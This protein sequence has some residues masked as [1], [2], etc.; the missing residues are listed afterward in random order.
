M[1][2]LNSLESADNLL[3][4]FLVG[5]TFFLKGNGTFTF[6]VTGLGGKN[7]GSDIVETSSSSPSSGDEVACRFEVLLCGGDLEA[8]L[9]RRLGAISSS[10]PTKCRLE[11]MVVVEQN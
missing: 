6:A 5:S 9:L 11:S 8:I 7:A 2:C 3:V 10:Q 1:P 4:P